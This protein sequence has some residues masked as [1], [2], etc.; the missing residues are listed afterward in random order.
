MGEATLLPDRG[1]EILIPVCA[2]IGIAFAFVQWLF[3]GQGEAFKRKGLCW[4]EKWIH[5]GPD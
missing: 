1:T 4:R 3:G 2:V 5:G